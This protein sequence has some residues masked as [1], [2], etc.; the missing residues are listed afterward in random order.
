VTA[1]PEGLVQ[2]RKGACCGRRGCER[3]PKATPEHPCWQGCEGPPESSGRGM[4]EERRTRTGDAP[5]APGGRTPQQYGRPL[6]RHGRGNPDPEPC[7]NLGSAVAPRRGKRRRLVS[8]TTRGML[9]GCLIMHSP[10]RSGKPTTGGRTGRQYAARPGH[11]C[12]TRSDRTTRSQP[13]GR[14]SPTKRKPT[15]S[16]AFGSWTGAWMQ[17][18]D[19]TAGGT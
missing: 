10:R 13:P 14:A 4:Q 11:F 12:R 8:G 5:A 6:L 18:C 3:T 17:T 7:W 19:A 9:L 2:L 16:P 1:H 15:S